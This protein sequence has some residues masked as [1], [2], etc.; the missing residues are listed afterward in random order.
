M[1]WVSRN[2]VRLTRWS[3]V[4][5][6]IVLFEILT[7]LNLLS[8]QTFISPSAT[9]VQIGDLLSSSDFVTKDLSQTLLSVVVAWLGGSAAGVLIGLVVARV[10]WLNRMTRPYLLLF[11]AL[12]IFALYPLVVALFGAGH[13]SITLLGACYAGVNVVVDTSISMRA[14]KPVWI[15]TARLVGLSGWAEFIHVLLPA[16]SIGIFNGVR[17]AL[18][19]AVIV[20]VGSEFLL[21]D[22]GLGRRIADAY[23]GF[24]LGP[25]YGCI[26]L[27][28]LTIL[29]LDAILSRLQRSL[30]RG[31][32]DR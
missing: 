1:S 22:S 8:P 23:N 2:A 31:W 17:L 15:K 27:V 12:P 11:Y 25:M 13:N 18:S 30:T 29:V 14:A 20:V 7:R 6:V 24:Q 21:S 4:I 16:A 19:Y 3:L 26:A 10:D 5:G 32:V 28:V 9:V